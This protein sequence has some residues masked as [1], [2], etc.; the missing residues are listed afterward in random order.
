MS[1]NNNRGFTLIELMITLVVI[2]IIAAFA[3]PSLGDFVTKRKLV[4]AAEEVYSQL[5]LARSLAIKRNQTIYVNFA[6]DG[7]S[8]WNFGIGDYSGCTP[9]TTSPTGTTPC[10]IY[11]L[12]GDATSTRILHRT[13]S[14]NFDNV[15]MVVSGFGSDE[16]NFEPQRGTADNGN[17]LMTNDAG[18]LKVV[19]S[20]IGR[21]LI[22][23]PAG[24]TYIS[25]YT[26]CS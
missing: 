26:E 16:T 3:V 18:Q 21:I 8:T 22:C 4:G 19:V 11:E 12:P 1:K 6:E 20:T 14:S 23:S 17:V 24:S 15:S 5:Q 13:S 7:S 9:A 10:A 25:G 2:S